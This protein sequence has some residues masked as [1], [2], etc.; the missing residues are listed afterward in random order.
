MD[1][2]PVLQI[3]RCRLGTDIEMNRPGYS[4]TMAAT[5]AAAAAHSHSH[6]PVHHHS[7][8]ALAVNNHAHFT[9][10]HYPHPCGTRSDLINFFSFSL[11][12]FFSSREK[13]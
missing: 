1:G 11:S 5:A 10:T 12:I 8:A 9:R 7:A 4:L 3:V 13:V 2:F 6:L